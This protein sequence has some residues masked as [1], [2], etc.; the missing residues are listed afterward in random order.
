[1]G[2]L[3]ESIMQL[4]VDNGECYNN[5]PAGQGTASAGCAHDQEQIL[6]LK[7][8]IE[9]PEQRAVTRY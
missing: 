3:S 6:L 9:R 2:R 7:A 1:M 4:M 5:R 8:Q